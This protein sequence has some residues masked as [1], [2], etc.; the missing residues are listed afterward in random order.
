MSIQFEQYECFRINF[1]NYSLLYYPLL[2]TMT[3]LFCDDIEEDEVEL[4]IYD[5][6]GFHIEKSPI[7]DIKL[8]TTW[9]MYFKEQ[10]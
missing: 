4:Q 2:Q 7:S 1:D 6:T 10:K 8:L 5:E 3:I 9:L